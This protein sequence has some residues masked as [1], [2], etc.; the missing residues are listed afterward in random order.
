MCEKNFENSKVLLKNQWNINI[1]TLF[2]MMPTFIRDSEIRGR[3]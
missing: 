1:I 2:Q 3:K